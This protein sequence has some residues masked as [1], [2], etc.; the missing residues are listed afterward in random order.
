MLINLAYNAEMGFMLLYGRGHLKVEKI[1][2]AS[3]YQYGTI[4]LNPYPKWLDNTFKKLRVLC[5]LWMYGVPS[6]LS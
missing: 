1:G 4:C 2:I 3:F 5:F 6:Q